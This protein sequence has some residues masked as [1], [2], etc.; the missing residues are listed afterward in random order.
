MGLCPDPLSFCWVHWHHYGTIMRQFSFLLSCSNSSLSGSFRF[1]LK[2]P[3][4][5]N[6]ASAL[7]FFNFLNRDYRRLRWDGL[8]RPEGPIQHMNGC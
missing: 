7:F 1:H 3:F 5:I 2:D 6:E 4:G 8:Q